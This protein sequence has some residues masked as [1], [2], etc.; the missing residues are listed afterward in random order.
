M[1]KHREQNEQ[2]RT[3]IININLTKELLVWSTVV[4]SAI[5][6]LGYL[7]WGGQEAAA[8]G[9]QVAPAASTGMRQFYLDDYPATGA[10]AL[11]VCA[12]G[13]HMASLWEILDPSNLRYNPELGMT[14]DDSGAGP[15]TYWGWV[16]TGYLADTDNVAGRANCDAWTTS[17]GAAYGTIVNLPNGAWSPSYAD[18]H[19]WYAGTSPCSNY[20]ATWCVED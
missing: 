4:I 2:D 16:R 8:A 5:V 19:V 14:R 1:S 3:L 11:S 20:N 7:I 10:T 12:E 9:R 17:D 6:F 18:L 15:V 13:Y